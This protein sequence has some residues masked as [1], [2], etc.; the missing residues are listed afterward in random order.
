MFCSWRMRS[1]VTPNFL[2]TSSSVF[3][4]P[5][6]SPK[7]EKMIFLSRSSSTSSRPPTSLRRFLSRSNSKGVCASSSPTISPNS[8]ESSSLIGASSEAGRIETVLSCETLPAGD[9]D[10]FA[11]LV[12]GRFAAEFL[13]HLQRNA[14]H[15]GDLVD[16]MDRQADRL[17]LVGQGALDRLLDPPGGVGARACRPWPGR[18]AP[19]PSS[20]RCCL[21]KSGRAAADPRLA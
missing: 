13:A 4:L 3:G 14:A 17:A 5:P 21:R 11:E 19:P 8:V 7:R 12:V 6:S 20:G 9:A 18:N 2:P 15:L 10:F 16:Q 1:R